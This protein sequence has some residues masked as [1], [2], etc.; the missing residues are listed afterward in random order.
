MN[1]LEVIFVSVFLLLISFFGISSPNNSFEWLMTADNGLD[2]MRVCLALILIG[3][4]LSSPIS[5]RLPSTV[6]TTSG[7]F[8]LGILIGNV[9]LPG[10]YQQIGLHI[11]ALD[12]V[13]FVEGFIVCTLY[14][15]GDQG[16]ANDEIITRSKT[17]LAKHAQ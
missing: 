8:M 13:A 5:S 17:R 9:M 11:F 16:L 2:V 12:V 4:A 3:F 15:L 14:G 1:R 6:V 10:L 7:F